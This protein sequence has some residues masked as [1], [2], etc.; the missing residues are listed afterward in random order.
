MTF[1][2]PSSLEWI[3]DACFGESGLVGFETPPALRHPG[4]SVFERCII[5]VVKNLSRAP[6]RIRGRPST[7]FAWSEG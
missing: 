1:G 7:R 6:P 5:N 3:G 4:K 2:S